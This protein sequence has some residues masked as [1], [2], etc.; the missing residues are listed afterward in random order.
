MGAQLFIALALRST[1]GNK[2]FE[3]LF[4]S[5]F[6]LT[7]R[8]AMSFLRPPSLGEQ[9]R[10]QVRTVFNHPTYILKHPGGHAR[11]YNVIQVDNDIIFFDPDAPQNIISEADLEQLLLQNYNAPRNYADE[12]TLWLWRE[13]PEH[14]HPHFAPKDFGAMA[15][16]SDE[17]ENHVLSETDWLNSKED[18]KK[19]ELRFVLDF[20]DLMK[21]IEEIRKS[22]EVEAALAELSSKIQSLEAKYA[23][24]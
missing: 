3:M 2:D 7:Q 14:I 16:E 19:C 9:S 10:I 22:R 11:L 20:P 1:I 4:E 15:K 17:Y 5:K 8:W 18:R 24:K 6:R 13:N 23:L 21:D 12:E